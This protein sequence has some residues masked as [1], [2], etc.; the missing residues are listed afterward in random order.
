MS[1]QNPKEGK[2]AEFFKDPDTYRAM[3]E[4]FE[5]SEEANAAIN[6]FNTDLRAI[7]A[8]YGMRDVIALISGS[9]KVEGAEEVD[10]CIDM[11]HG[12]EMKQEYLLAWALG[13]AQ[14]ERQE[15][16]SH[17]MRQAIQRAEKRR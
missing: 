13:K 9:Y 12:D 5:S 16:I 17:V 7:R 3:C 6:G 11:M 10:F 1:E 15:R 14:A 4:P 8:K 2:Q